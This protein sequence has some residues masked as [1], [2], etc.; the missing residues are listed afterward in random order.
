MLKKHSSQQAVYFIAEIVLKSTAVARFK[1]YRGL[2]VTCSE[3]GNKNIPPAVVCQLKKKTHHM[4]KL[5][6]ITIIIVFLIGCKTTSEVSYRKLSDSLS[7]YRTTRLIN[8]DTIKEVSK[9]YI[10]FENRNCVIF[11]SVDKFINYAQKRI[12]D[13]ICIPK[14]TAFNEVLEILNISKGNHYLIENEISPEHYRKLHYPNPNR[15]KK[16]FIEPYGFATIID[17][18]DKA[19]IKRLKNWMISELCI[20]GLCLVL[21]KRNTV[22]VDKIYYEIIDF[23]DGHGGESLKFS[24]KKPFFNVKVYSDIAWPD[25]DCMTKEEIIEWKSK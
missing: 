5:N 18:V 11:I 7:E 10:E 6:F 24:D 14:K 13:S 4:N 23:K 1:L 19:E 22:F 15:Y 17:T 3:I 16:N 21:D 20:S 9:N 25:F 2:I 8:T 12:N